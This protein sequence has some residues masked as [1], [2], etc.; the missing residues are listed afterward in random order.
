VCCCDCRSRDCSSPSPQVA[1]AAFGSAA[2][3]PEDQHSHT[4]GLLSCGLAAAAA[5][6]LALEEC[7]R[8]HMLH[9]FTGGW[10]LQVAAVVFLGCLAGFGWRGWWWAAAAGGGRRGLLPDG[11]QARCRQPLGVRMWVAYVW[12]AG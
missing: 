2:E 4:L 9:T 8:K 12:G 6:A 1:R 10:G 5:A 11:A 7:A 3:P